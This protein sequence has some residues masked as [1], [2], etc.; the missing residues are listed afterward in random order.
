[1]NTLTANQEKTLVWDLFVRLFHW[2]LVFFIGFAWW[3]GEQGG[4]WM[5]WHMRCG[6]AVL[7]LVIFR[8]MWGFI[9]S[10]Y[11]RFTHFIYSPKNTL[12]YIRALL[13]RQEPVYASHNPVG[14]WAVVLLLLL[15]AVQAGT[16]LFAND[17]IFTE[18][19]LAHL[20]GYD[21]SIEITKWHKLLFNGL[22]AV[23]VVH[24]AGVV[25]HQRFRKEPLLQGMISGKKPTSGAVDVMPQTATKSPLRVFVSGLIVILLAILLVWGLLSL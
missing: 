5:Q 24:V 17:D 4:E 16:G 21:L 12:S 6:Y 15:C 14:G 20:V 3:T 22:L 19:P 25:Y 23:I 9:G 13:K 10:F 7:G 2:A 18:G 8:L 1:M 11:A